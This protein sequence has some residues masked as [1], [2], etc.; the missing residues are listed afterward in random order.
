MLDALDFHRFA[1]VLERWRIPLAP[2]ALGRLAGAMFGTSIARE[3]C[4][5]PGTELA[6]GGVGV[7]IQPQAR[8][9]RTVCVGPHVTIGGRAAQ[10]APVVEDDVRIG[11]GACLLGAI[12]V[13][14]GALIGANAVVTSD[15]APFAIVAGAPAREIGRVE[16]EDRRRAS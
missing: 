7:V 8:L 16:A 4:I 5:G 3:A 11:A 15:V 12:R 13:G 1:Q 14:T 10:G 2:R 6:Y 9:G